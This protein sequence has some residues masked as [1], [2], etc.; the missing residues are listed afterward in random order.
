[1]Y[2]ITDD[3]SRKYENIDS[4]IQENL[5][6]FSEELGLELATILKSSYGTELSAIEL[7]EVGRHIMQFVLAQENIR[8]THRK[9]AV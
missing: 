8:H 1:M 5:N 7:Q 4:S 6:L 9:E 2:Q 3:L